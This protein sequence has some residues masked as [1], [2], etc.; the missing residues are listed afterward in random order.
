MKRFISFIGQAILVVL[1]VGL[2]AAIVAGCGYAIIHFH[3]TAVWQW[4]GMGLLF[5]ICLALLVGVIL[6]LWHMSRQADLVSI[7]EVPGYYLLTN[8]GRAALCFYIF[9]SFA[10][11]DGVNFGMVIHSYLTTPVVKVT[12]AQLQPK[13]SGLEKV[14][15][16]H[17]RTYSQPQSEAEQEATE[18]KQAETPQPVKRPA[19]LWFFIWCTTLVIVLG[20]VSFVYYPISRRDEL[21]ELIKH[22]M[23]RINRE[24]GGL[25]EAEKKGTWRHILEKLGFIKSAPEAATAAVLVAAATPVVGGTPA[26]AGVS[27][28]A[29]MATGLALPAKTGW[30]GKWGHWLAIAGLLLEEVLEAPGIFR[31]RKK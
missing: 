6:F 10:L 30:W 15:L 25:L 29:T 22:V 26:P 19:S 28:A 4:L 27:P 13:R 23:E 21:R 8:N 9:I 11:L 31:R 7:F 14:I 17:K 2:L 3:F 20:L 1:L 16:R 5:G 18:K 24:S 12:T